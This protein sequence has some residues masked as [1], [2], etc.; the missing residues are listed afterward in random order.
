MV[1]TDRQVAGTGHLPLAFWRNRS[2][3]TSK[4]AGYGLEVTGSSCEGVAR[5]TVVHLQ[6]TLSVADAAACATTD[7]VWASTSMSTSAPSGA[8]PTPSSGTCGMVTTRAPA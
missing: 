5:G 1:L 6:M 4:W 8:G 3:A 7:A 2:P